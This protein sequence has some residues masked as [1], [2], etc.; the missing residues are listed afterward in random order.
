MKKK[1]KEKKTMA[2]E[3]EYQIVKAEC[4]VTA[5]T[6]YSPGITLRHKF[7]QQIVGE[8]HTEEEA[9]AE[10]KKYY[11]EWV[12]DGDRIQVVEYMLCQY[13][14]EYEDYTITKISFTV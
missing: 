9:M 7:R 4:T 1:G 11:T 6:T 13:E 5:G 8:Y 2:V 10:W 14:P 3:H 12:P